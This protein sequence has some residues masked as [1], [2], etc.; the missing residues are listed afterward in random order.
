MGKLL[1]CTPS[2]AW[3]QT[4]EIHARIK[5][6]NQKIDENCRPTYLVSSLH[7]IQLAIKRTTSFLDIK[8]PEDL[9]LL[10]IVKTTEGQCQK[11]NAKKTDSNPYKT[12]P[13]KYQ[14]NWPKVPANNP[15][16]QEIPEPANKNRD[17]KKTPPQ[18]RASTRT[19]TET[20]ASNFGYYISIIMVKNNKNKSTTQPS[21]SQDASFL[22]ISRD[23]GYT[24]MKG[25]PKGS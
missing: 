19:K 23:N 5:P 13:T 21:S 8:H 3:V 14:T 10:M 22:K 6:K 12:I 16:H 9:A 15:R 24:K 11:V 17:V 18:T 2:T 7:T 25:Q 4:C 20:L 1:T